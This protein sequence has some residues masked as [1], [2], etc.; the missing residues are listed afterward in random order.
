MLRANYS[1]GTVV[2]KM[3]HKRSAPSDEADE[4]ET[5]VKRA[6]KGFSVG[7]A[8]LPDGSHRRKG[9]LSRQQRMQGLTQRQYKR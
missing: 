6:K 4:G 1:Q 2:E 5:G 3:A 9:R 7:S 8:N